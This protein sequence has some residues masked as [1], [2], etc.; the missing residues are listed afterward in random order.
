MCR[1]KLLLY[2]TT[3]V[4]VCMKGDGSRMRG[5]STL[6]SWSNEI[7]SCMRSHESFL[8]SRVLVKREQELHEGCEELTSEGL[9]K[10]FL[11]SH[12]LVKPKFYH[13]LLFLLFRVVYIFSIYWI[14]KLVESH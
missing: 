7:K 10:R 2:S 8:H 4:H 14:I 6:V 13:S 12:V 11:N 3:I 5:F 1:G 9:Y